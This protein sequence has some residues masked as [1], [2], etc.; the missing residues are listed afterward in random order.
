LGT[1]WEGNNIKK[2]KKIFFLNKSLQ[3]VQPVDRLAEPLTQK[4]ALVVPKKKNLLFVLQ[5]VLTYFNY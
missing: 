3:A 1:F 2:I 4:T 5:L